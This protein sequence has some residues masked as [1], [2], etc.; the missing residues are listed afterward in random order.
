MT[1]DE[2]KLFDMSAV[3]TAEAVNYVAAGRAEALS[4]LLDDTNA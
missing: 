3:I 1:V 2:Y 4:I